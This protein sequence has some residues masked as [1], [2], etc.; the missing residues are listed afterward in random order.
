MMGNAVLA[1]LGEVFLKFSTQAPTMGGP[2]VA[3]KLS[4]QVNVTK[5]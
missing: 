5:R 2:S 4:E 1:N 3:T